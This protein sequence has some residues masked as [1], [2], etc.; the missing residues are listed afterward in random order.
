MALEKMGWLSSAL[1]VEDRL[2]LR[3]VPGLT[4]VISSYGCPGCWTCF[5]VLSRFVLGLKAWFHF[6]CAISSLKV[7]ESWLIDAYREIFRSRDR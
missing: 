4:I 5:S 3:R 6:G 2:S 7:V 1:D